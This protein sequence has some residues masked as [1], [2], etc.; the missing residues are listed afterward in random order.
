MNTHNNGKRNDLNYK[1][2]GGNDDMF[3][4]ANEKSLPKKLSKQKTK[5]TQ[6]LS[7][8]MDQTFKTMNDISKNQRGLSNLTYQDLYEKE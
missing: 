5:R 8:A 2:N 6:L 4:R 7:V 1:N 3:A